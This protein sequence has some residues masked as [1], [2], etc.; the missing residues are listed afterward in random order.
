[1]SK[2]TPE[3]NKAL[4]L[5]AFDTLFN[6]RDYGAAERFW[7]DRYIQTARTSRRAETVF[8]I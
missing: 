7:S 6:R 8:S 2:T 4:V 3:Q 5:E 1:M